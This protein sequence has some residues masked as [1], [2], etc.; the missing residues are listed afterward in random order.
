MIILS[1][2][3][4]ESIYIY[5]YVCVYVYVYVCIGLFYCL[6]PVSFYQFIR[7][8]QVLSSGLP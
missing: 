1:N 8:V 5:I 7:V 6:I 4:D 2:A 3:F